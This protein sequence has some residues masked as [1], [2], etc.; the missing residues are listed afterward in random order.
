VAP[1]TD[2]GRSPIGSD[3]VCGR[4]ALGELTFGE[5]AS[6]LGANPSPAVAERFQPS[7][8]IAPTDPVLGV[9]PHKGE[10]VL[11]FY[12]WGLVPS[13]SKDPKSGVRA[14]NA[15]AET[16]RE[17]PLFR[18]AF[19]R[20]RLLMPA[21]GYFEW[22]GQGKAKQPYYFTRRDREPMMFAALY[23]VWRANHDD[24]WLLTCAIIVG[25]ANEDAAEVHDRMPVILER[26]EWDLWLD[27]ELDPG[28]ASAML[29]PA[30]NG[31]LEHRPVSPRVGNVA[32]NDPTLI[33]PVAD[34]PAQARTSH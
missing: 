33:E 12:R 17:N 4:Y 10:R 13:W 14:I 5:I 9:A 32:N 11:D 26:P 24:P 2:R 20:R 1:G 27:P 28:H 15:R 8:N 19:E 31:L 30:A 29:D 7:Y 22:K 16:V 23:E 18:A 3:G 21:S 6:L 34:A 25:P